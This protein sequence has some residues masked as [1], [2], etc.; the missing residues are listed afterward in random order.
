MYRHRCSHLH[1]PVIFNS[2]K[3]VRAVESEIE[4]ARTVR[5]NAL[6]MALPTLFAN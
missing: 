1:V 4:N 5:S 6:K 3:G 2:A